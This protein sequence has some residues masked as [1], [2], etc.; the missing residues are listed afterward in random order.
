M[1][2]A[3]FSNDWLQRLVDPYAILGISV[4][5]DD[6]RLFKRY[7]SVAMLL[8]PD[9]HIQ[10]LQA[11]REAAESLIARTINP[12]YEKVKQEKNRAEVTALLRLQARR[13]T[14]E[15]TLVPNSDL[16]RELMRQPVQAADIFYEQAVT[17]LAE[18]QFSP[19]GNFQEIVV[20][21]GELNLIYLQL[22]MGDLFREKRSG[23]ISQ[24]E[25][26]VTPVQ[27]AAIKVATTTISYASRH[28]DRA[29]QYMQKGISDKAIL[30]LKDAIRLEPNQAEYHALMSY[31]Y[32]RQNLGGMAKVYCRQALKL[33]PTS[34][35]GKQVAT[36]L[37]MVEPQ[38]NA[39]TPAVAEKRGLFSRFR[40]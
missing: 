18:A 13:H 31:A 29:Q 10:A 17:Q 33:D 30:E 34:T 37:G 6:K 1:V 39:K 38:G 36:K 35:L 9:R 5:A 11:D 16:A 21:L 7:R 32:L 23:L 14:R 2:Q 19:I 28:F 20:T 24:A 26:P 15:G 27:E 3:A 12:A 25:I 40:R 4:A 8:H 22:K